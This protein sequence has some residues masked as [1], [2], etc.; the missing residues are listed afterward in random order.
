MCKN[1]EVTVANC[2]RS[3]C[4]AVSNSTWHLNFCT[5]IPSSFWTCSLDIN[6]IKIR[7]KSSTLRALFW[8][9]ITDFNWLK[10]KGPLLFCK[11]AKLCQ[12]KFVTFKVQLSASCWACRDLSMPRPECWL[13]LRK[14]LTTC[15]KLQVCRNYKETNRQVF[16][17]PLDL[18]TFR[19]TEFILF[20]IYQYSLRR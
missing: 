14:I 3:S 4:P 5:I 20:F 7:P 1:L 10:S 12:H 13:N 18:L 2:S 19:F 9:K 11:S 6:M 17:S 15:L 8:L 16:S